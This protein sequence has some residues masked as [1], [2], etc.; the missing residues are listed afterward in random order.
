[1]FTL[2]DIFRNGRIEQPNPDQCLL[3]SSY[4]YFLEF[5]FKINWSMLYTTF[6][7]VLLTPVSAHRGVGSGAWKEEELRGGGHT[8][9]QNVYIIDAEIDISRILHNKLCA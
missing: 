9:V 4:I 3:K 7:R 1:M 8:K 6:M 5:R 2:K